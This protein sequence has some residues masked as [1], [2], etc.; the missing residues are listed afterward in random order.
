LARD[1]GVALDI[2]GAHPAEAMP[3]L[4][5]D[6]R[7]VA[8][9]STYEPFSVAALE[10]LAAGRPVVLSDATGA[11]EVLGPEQGASVYPQGDD[12]AL[13]AVLAPLLDDAR[14]ATDAGERGRAHVRAAHSPRAAAEAKLVAWQA[15]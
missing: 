12:A 10:G 13:A 11:A 15:R 14:L 1:L 5:A 6:V 7:V 2:A 9:P 3:A 4:L 8:V